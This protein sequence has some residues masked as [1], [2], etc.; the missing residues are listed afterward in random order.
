MA[1][2]GASRPLVRGEV[3]RGADWVLLRFAR[4]VRL[5]WFR[6]VEVEGIERI[7]ADRPVLVAA[8]HANGFVDPVTLM[9]TSPRPLRFLAKATLW[10][11]K[12]LGA[13]MELA[14]A[15][16]IFRHHD[17]TT[18]G[19]ASTFAACYRELAAGG[20]I[21]IFPEGT[22]ND[23]P[24][25]LP[26][27]T[28]AARIAL[29]ARHAGTRG[30]R[31]LP[32]GL[33]Y[34]DKARPRTRVLVRA[35]EPIDLDEVIG[36]LVDAGADEGPANRDAVERLTD[37]IAVG[38]A[39]AS[40]DYDE[41]PD[42]VLLLQ[43][44]RVASRR[45]EADP[46]VSPLLGEEEP[47]LRRLSRAEPERRAAVV[48]ATASYQAELSLLGLRDSDVVPGNTPE[49]MR[50]RIGLSM[51]KVIGLAPFAA[52]GA[53]IDLLPYGVVRVVAGRPMPRI[54]RANATLL[55]S[56]VVFPLTWLLWGI[57]GRRLGVKHPWRWA[58]LAGPLCGQA[59][60]IW[61]EQ[62]RDLRAAR[63]AWHRTRSQADLLAD[64]LAHRQAVVDAVTVATEVAAAP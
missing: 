10:K 5:A 53:A 54:S 18:E 27:H 34:E 57:C 50:Q 29:G 24:R 4:T 3:R 28:G 48:A 7:S 26:L 64:V 23:S 37:R 52:V 41:S 6:V 32:V 51:T 13:L 11:S 14:G 8:N 63:V 56:L 44:V 43:A 46:A 47:L 42:N 40:L 31:I 62:L 45:P 55:L 35:G 12:P 33:V 59:T 17:G 22:V 19:N 58:L 39:E 38:L 1:T 36:E 21:G 61:W 49:R 16:P 15:L 60:V 20:I 9:A 25:L 30:I 2:N